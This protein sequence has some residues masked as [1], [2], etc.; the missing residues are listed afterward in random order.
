MDPT[1]VKALVDNK[2]DSFFSSGIYVAKEKYL[3]I[4]ADDR[5]TYGK[6]VRSCSLP[7]SSCPEA[8]GV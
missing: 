8:D 1:E 5:S 7:H 3:A 2:Q 6:K 4:K